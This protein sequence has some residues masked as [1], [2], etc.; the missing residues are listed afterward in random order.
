MMSTRSRWILAISALVIIPAFFMPIWSI[1]L[2]APQYPDGIGMHI[3]MDQLTGH[4]RHDIQ[5]INILNHYVGMAEIHE[6]DFWEFDVMPYIFGVLVALGLLAALGGRRWMLWTWVTLFILL[7]IGGLADFYYWGYQYG[8][9][10]D[11][12][13]AIKVPDMTYQPPLIGSKTLL[14]ITAYSWPYWG[15]AF[16]GASLLGGLGAL[17]YEYRQRLQSLYERLFS[18]K[19]SNQEVEA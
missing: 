10:L 14:N 5:N 12:R 8:H 13:A 7:A 17:G 9:D 19:S 15:A 11:P 2:K 18:S 6:E 3:W 1:T 4:E 16:I